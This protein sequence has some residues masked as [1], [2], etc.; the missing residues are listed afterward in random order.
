MCATVTCFSAMIFTVVCSTVSSSLGPTMA[1]K[2]EDT[3]AMRRAVDY[4]K[5]DRRQIVAAFTLGVIAFYV[6]C[7]VLIWVKLLHQKWNAAICLSSDE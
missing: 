6:V 3:S 4:M 2:G 5:S 7:L 1:L